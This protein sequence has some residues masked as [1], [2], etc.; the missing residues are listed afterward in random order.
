MTHDCHKLDAFLDGE[1]SPGDGARFETHLAS[2]PTCREAID[3]QRWIDGL[4]RG[5]SSAPLET[6][7]PALA[8]NLRAAIA[9]RRRKWLAACGLAASAAALLLIAVGWTVSQNQQAHVALGPAVSEEPEPTATFVGG[10]D[11]IAVPVESDLPD[12]TIVRVY[13]VYE[14]DYPAQ[15]SLDQTSP[16]DEFAWPN[17][18]GG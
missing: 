18:N 13:P 4:L 6:P 2:C 10:P 16:G 11:V 17:L 9:G 14:P 7:V 1:L 3:E 8:V 5:P 12:V 15:F